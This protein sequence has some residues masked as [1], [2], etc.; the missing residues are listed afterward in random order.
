M[1]ELSWA[2][3]VIGVL[4]GFAGALGAKLGAYEMHF[5]TDQPHAPSTLLVLGV[6]SLVIAIWLGVL[7][8]REDR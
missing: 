4:L 3:G 5:M 8:S 2:A 6:L 1:K 7:G